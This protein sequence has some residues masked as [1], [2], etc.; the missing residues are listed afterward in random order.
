MTIWRKSL[1]ALQQ[2]RG[3]HEGCPDHERTRPSKAD[4]QCQREIANEVFDLPTE[5]RTELQFRGTEGCE[6]EQ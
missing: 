6:Y 3:G 4:Q 2:Y 1:Q 5:S